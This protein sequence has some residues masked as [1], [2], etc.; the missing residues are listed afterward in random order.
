MYLDEKQSSTF[1]FLIGVI[2]NEAITGRLIITGEGRLQLHN[3]FNAGELFNFHF[4]KL[5]STSKELQT[6]LVYPYL[7]K[8]PIGLEGSFSLYLKDST[9]LERTTSAGVLFQMTGNNYFKALANFYN[10]QCWQLTP[11]IS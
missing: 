11:D 6:S 5:E 4:S 1:D 7:P 8:L 10:L 9:F 2:P 3:V